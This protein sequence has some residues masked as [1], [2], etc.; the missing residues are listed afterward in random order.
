MSMWE[1]EKS[2][3]FEIKEVAE[4]GTFTGFASIYG[5]VDLQNEVVTKGAFNRTLDHKNNKI[6]LLWQHNPHEPIGVG[7]VEDSSV[8]LKIKGFL[9]LEVARAKEAYALLKQGAIKGLSIGYDTL[10]DDWKGGVRY[11]KELKLWEVSVVTFPA[12][13]IA[14]VNGIKS[15]VPFQNLPLA[16]KDTSWDGSAAKKAIKEWATDEN[17]DI[18]FAKYKKGFIWFDKNNAD[19]EGAYKLPVATIIDG[20][21]TAVPKSIY[22]CAAAVQGA[23]G[24]LKIPANEVAGVKTHIAKY[25][26]KL[27]EKPPWVKGM[28]DMG[29]EEKNAV[30][31]DNALASMELRDMRWKM[32]DALYTAIQATIDDDEMADDEKLV[33]IGM[34]LDQHK[35]A[36]LSWAEAMLNNIA[37]GGTKDGEGPDDLKSGRAISGARMAKLKQALTSLSDI[38]DTIDA[39]L[40]EVEPSKDSGEET[41]STK[42][43]DLEGLGDKS[44]DDIVNEMKNFKEVK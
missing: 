2:F 8:G 34:S 39:L 5:N 33:S 20:K 17:G 7:E 15:V 29:L 23:R 26:S 44:I 25:Y 6:T 30:S 28:D 38:K 12:N 42:N 13:P 11:L 37:E 43:D 10:K 18:D 21:L 3:K 24:G 40:K 35:D 4:D 36:F 22:A 14:G 16:D 32:S 41:D 9:N 27:G 19:T 31:F 1:S